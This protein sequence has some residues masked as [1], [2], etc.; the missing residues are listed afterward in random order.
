[1]AIDYRKEVDSGFDRKRIV[2]ANVIAL[3]KEGVPIEI[4]KEST[5]FNPRHFEMV[6]N[7]Q[8]GYSKKEEE[9]LQMY[10]GYSKDVQEQIVPDRYSGVSHPIGGELYPMTAEEEKEK[11]SL[12][13]S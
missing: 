4:I 10:G 7:L 12:R 9:L 1:M 3:L 5:I 11:F 8:R 13:D 2:E 6:N